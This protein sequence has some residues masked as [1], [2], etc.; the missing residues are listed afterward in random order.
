M[1]R[2]VFFSKMNLMEPLCPLLVER[3]NAYIY[4]EVNFDGLVMIFKDELCN[5]YEYITYTE[6]IHQIWKHILLYTEG[7]TPIT[8]ISVIL[9]LYNVKEPNPNLY[10]C[11]R[12]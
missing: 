8:I 5:F 10:G 1:N 6:I 12:Y 2:I 3:E 7:N 11:N 4:L 9:F